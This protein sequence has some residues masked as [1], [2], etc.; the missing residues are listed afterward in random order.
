MWAF[1]STRSGFHMEK[2]GHGRALNMQALHNILYMPEYALTKFWTYLGFLIC[3]N[4]E[5][6]RVLNMSHQV[7]IHY[8]ARAHSLNY[9]VFWE[10]CVFRTLSKMQDTAL[11]KNN[12]SFQVLSQNTLFNPK[13]LILSKIKRRIKR[14]PQNVKIN[15]SQEFW[16][17]KTTLTNT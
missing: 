3:K 8:I 2:T 15:F 13:G 12:Y 11:W 6:D 5:F 14:F 7:V 9:W 17:L 10:M 16:G 1:C 4:S